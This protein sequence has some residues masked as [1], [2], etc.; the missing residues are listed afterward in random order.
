MIDI[1]LISI[2]E[3]IP[4][5][6]NPRIIKDDKYKKLVE[7][8]RD[9][10][11]MLEL[12]PLVIDK[13]NI[14]IGG[15]MRLRALQELKYKEVPI[16]YASELTKE[17]IKKFIILDNTEFGSWDYDVLSNEYEI[18]ELE[19]LGFDV[20][21]NFDAFPDLN[22]EISLDDLG[23]SVCY[24]KLEYSMTD[25]ELLKKKIKDSGKTAESIFYEAL[26]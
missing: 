2:S 7:S 8:L 3:L 25:Y 1:K 23:N 24:F 11:K 17:E 12:R 5:P 13:D 20:G 22:K 18:E 9:F 6:K 21:N 10:P 16:V 19:N 4:N 15:N 26:V 14:V